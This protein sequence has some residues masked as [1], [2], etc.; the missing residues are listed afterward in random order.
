MRRAIAPLVVGL[1]VLGACGDGDDATNSASTSSSTSAVGSSS[2]D[3]PETRFPDV[4]DA[5]AVQGDDGLFRFEVTVSSPYDSAERYADAWRVIAPDGAELGIRELAHD[6]AGEQ[7]FTRALDGVEVPPGITEVTIEA[8]DSANGWGGATFEVA[9]PQ[10]ASVTVTTVLVDDTAGFRIVVDGIEGGGEIPEQFTC[11][12]ANDV[13]PVRPIG[14]PDGTGQ[15]A[16][17]VDD[18]DAPGGTF[19]H[20]V[21][22]DIDP[23]T[24]AI[25]AS[26]DDVTFG[27]NDLGQ[28]EWFG[29]CPPPD[30]GPHEYR[31]RLFAIDGEP[32]LTAGLDAITLVAEIEDFITE[33]TEFT[34][35]YDR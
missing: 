10:S 15:L 25:G 34:A 9:I 5:V 27:R 23:E 21:V 24:T 1:V 6:H 19:V 28:F 29:P 12:G 16:L 20:W 18:P 7:P 13:P 14:V 31:W 30:D 4:I 26:G 2:T 11:D 17:V 8:R 32:D 3:S 22:Y 35:I 33:G